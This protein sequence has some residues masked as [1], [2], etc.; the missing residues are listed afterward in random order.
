MLKHKTR[1]SGCQQWPQIL[2]I[3]EGES[4]KR[5]FRTFPFV[6]AMFLLMVLP[7]GAQQ[8]SSTQGG[9]SG[10]I[11]DPTGAVVANAKVTVVGAS[12]KRSVLS[13]DTGQ[14]TIGS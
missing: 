2:Q 4:M 6:A 12:D 7:S 10:V 11:T 3:I 5:L 9:L 13:D 1:I 8:L 14:F